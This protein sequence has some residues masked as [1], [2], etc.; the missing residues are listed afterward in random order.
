VLTYYD[1]LG[2]AEDASTEQ[3]K[4]A[5]RAISKR[6]HPDRNPDDP[7]A[8]ERF[9]KASEAYSALS[10]PEARERYDQERRSE[11]GQAAGAGAKPEW[12]ADHQAAYDRFGRGGSSGPTGSPPPPPREPTP[13]YGGAG[14]HTGPHTAQ[15]GG[16]PPPKSQAPFEHSSHHA[17]SKKP[18]AKFWPAVALIVGGLVILSALSGLGDSLE[19]CHPTSICEE[20]EF[21]ERRDAGEFPEGTTPSGEPTDFY[22]YLSK[23]TWTGALWAGYGPKHHFRISFYPELEADDAA[24]HYSF[25]LENPEDRSEPT[26]QCMGTLVYSGT[27]SSLPGG[28]GESGLAFEERLSP[29][30]DSSCPNGTL[31]TQSASGSLFVVETPSTGS[32]LHGYLQD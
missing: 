19:S 14:V 24:G 4:Q 23:A 32:P 11:S 9:K 29:L 31:E 21:Q 22:N 1:I 30:A 28:S 17:R 27:R 2:V 18:K 20:E 15:G 26:L 12:D 6:D 25:R 10:D 13:N 3:I 7:T 16:T 8:G 5:F